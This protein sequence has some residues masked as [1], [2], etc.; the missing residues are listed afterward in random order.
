[1]IDPT[2][3]ET[4][5][6]AKGGQLGGEYLDSI[7]TSDLATLTEAEWARFIEAVVTAYCDHLR[8]LAARDHARIAAMTPEAPF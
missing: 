4:A 5:A 3:N 1:M 8:A 2:P 6:M 7:G